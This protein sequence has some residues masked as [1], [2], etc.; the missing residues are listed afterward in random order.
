VLFSAAGTG[1]VGSNQPLESMAGGQVAS[2]AQTDLSS[3]G[4]GMSGSFKPLA[5]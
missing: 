4:V 5:G 1:T 3:A 2:V